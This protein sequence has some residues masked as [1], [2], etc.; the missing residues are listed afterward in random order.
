[1]P[2]NAPALAVLASVAANLCQACPSPQA[3]GLRVLRKAPV[4]AGLVVRRITFTPGVLSFADVMMD[5][6]KGFCREFCMPDSDLSNGF[7]P[8]IVTRDADALGRA[9][10]PEF[11]N[12]KRYQY[13]AS[14]I[15]R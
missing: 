7:L 2:A 6:V 8:S 1:M 5:A 3:T 4:F 10:W 14:C 9:G 11:N 12:S 13:V 15:R